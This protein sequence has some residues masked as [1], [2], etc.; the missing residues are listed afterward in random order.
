MEC[1]CVFVDVECSYDFHNKIQRRAVKEHRCSECGRT[2]AVGETYEYVFGKW[3]GVISTYK[4]CKDCEILRDTFFCDGWY[5]EMLWENLWDYLVDIN[6][7]V[8]ASCILPLTEISKNKVFDMI[9][10]VWGYQIINHNSPREFLKDWYAGK[11]YY[12]DH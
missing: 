7:D 6:G 9:D 3:D 5:Y 12:Y 10:R 8:P 11:Y 1:A 4:T 2:I